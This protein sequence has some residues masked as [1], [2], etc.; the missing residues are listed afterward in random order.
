M[1]SFNDAV[2]CIRNGKPVPAIVLSSLS[3]DQGELLTLLY[4]DPDNGPQLIAQHTTRGIAKTQL[5]VA[6]WVG[7]KAFGWR[8]VDE[9]VIAP[10]PVAPAPTVITIGVPKGQVNLLD[11]AVIAEEV[12]RGEEQNAD[13]GLLSDSKPVFPENPANLESVLA[14]QSAGNTSIP[15]EKEEV[16]TGPDGKT[17]A[18]RGF[19]WSAT[20]DDQKSVLPA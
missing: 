16:A 1:K 15:V 9:V 8:E 4:A 13:A 20:S 18:E 2:I 7:G 5:A 17:D 14:A 3:S 12:K 19:P 10:K 11:P 6:P